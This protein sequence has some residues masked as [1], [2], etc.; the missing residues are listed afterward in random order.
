MAYDDIAR[1]IAQK[2]AHQAIRLLLEG[3]PP[4]PKL[5]R[6]TETELWDFKVDC[7]AT[8]HD[9]LTEN[10]WAHIAADVLAFHNNRGGLLLFGIENT[11]FRFVG[12]TKILDSKKFNDRIRKYVGDTI[13]V[14][15][16][17]EYIQADQR[18]LGVALVSPRGPTVARFKANAPQISGKRHFERGGS[19]IREKDSTRVLSPTAADQFARQQAVPTYGERY[20]IDQPY[21]R[22][23]APEYLHFLERSSLGTLIEKS[24]RDP[25]VAV[26]SL[27]GVGGM[28]KTALATWAAN[29]AYDAESFP[30]IVST[31]AKDRELSTT[32]ILGLAASLSSYE[33]LLDQICDVL[34][35]AEL[36]ALPVTQRETEVRQVITGSGGL[37]YVDNLETIDDKR[38][39]AF[40]DDLPQGVRALVTSRRNS[41]RTAARPIDIPPLTDKEITSFVRLLCSE[42]AYSHAHGLDDAQALEVGRAWDGIP[43]AIRWALARTKSIA[44]LLQQA[45]VPT[46]QRLHGDQL[47]E[48]SFRR[49][50][51][52]LSQAERA[53]LET[54]SILELAIPTEALV[55][56][57][58][59]AD[60][61]V[62][63]ATDELVDDGLVQRVFD[64][65]RNDYSF[66]LLPI[67][68]AFVRYDLQHRPDVSR[69]AQR[70][71][72]K[73]FEAGDVANEDER[74]VVREIR[75]GRNADD[76]ALVDLAIGAE[77]RG[78]LD[79]AERLYT[80]ALSRN[81]R[82]WRAARASAEFQRHKR[83]N[84]IEALSLYA[85]AGANAPKRGPERA[86][87]FREWGILLRESG[88]PDAFRRAE[89]KL[90]VAHAESPSDPIARHA[91]ATCYDR[92]GAYRLVIAL[93]EPV[94]GTRNEQTR[95]RSLPLLLKAYEKCNET[96]AAVELRRALTQ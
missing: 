44:E 12:A 50:F 7:P 63:D 27:I 62:L 16:H 17:R 88:K 23:L 69:S 55:A 18:H 8:A 92:R 64:D 65:D 42:P 47:L 72:T 80:Q 22:I 77:R 78:D 51:D 10:G 48:F 6:G 79:G 58:G 52:K 54:L 26:T 46:S 67:T 34:G 87:I 86:V 84:Y 81:P 60:D 70:R 24:L 59:M 76:S 14:D 1:A 53:V 85:T 25:R 74:L 95:L 45:A 57:A 40:L 20:S 5:G 31:T 29:R 49:V 83:R 71:L 36:K 3:D 75:A 15:Y 19:A 68:R 38:L 93:L 94:K 82:S 90:E 73:W 32:G 61:R 37:L 30:F 4:T 35:F 28:G 43:L 56:G 13:W 39:I 66:T 21:F 41:V 96:L 91:L 33:D 11:K 89:E 2:N 9:D